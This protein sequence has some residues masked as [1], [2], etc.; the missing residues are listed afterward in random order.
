MIMIYKNLFDFGSAYATN[1]DGNYPITNMDYSDFQGRTLLAPFRSIGTTSTITL[2]L[3]EEG[4]VNGFGIGN[5][6]VDTLTIEL[7]DIL[8]TLLFTANYTYDDLVNL[9]ND[10]EIITFDSVLNVKKIVFNIIGIT[11]PL[12][13]GELMPG[14]VITTPPAIA[15]DL[16]SPLTQTGSGQIT[17]EGAISGS[18][19]IILEGQ[20]FTFNSIS[21]SD[22]DILV[23]ASKYSRLNK[24]FFLKRYEESR[25][26]VWWC[27]Y[28]NTVLQQKM[29]KGPTYSTSFSVQEVR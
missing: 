8:D 12:S 28:T 27:R 25:L 17:D 13:I 11:D 14:M 7:Y 21:Q 15:D 6:N 9:Y 2:E 5:H 24:P 26:S 16:N 29:G 3:D 22:M 23:N 20:Q 1:A 19:G 10:L 4:P 18:D